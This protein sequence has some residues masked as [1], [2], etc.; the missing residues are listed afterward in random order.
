MTKNLQQIQATHRSRRNPDD[1]L[2]HDKRGSAALF[3]DVSTEGT[4]RARRYTS[5]L[6]AIFSGTEAALIWRTLS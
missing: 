2:S 6:T 5:A 3:E 1:R 4:R